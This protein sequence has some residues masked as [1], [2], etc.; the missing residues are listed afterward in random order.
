MHPDFPESMKNDA[1]KIKNLH[2]FEKYISGCAA[3][4]KFI[5]IRPDGFVMPCGYITADES[6]LKD[7]GNICLL[8]GI[9]P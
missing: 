8:Q 7:T 6:L 4:K 2:L 1:K 9:L 5:Y 3:G